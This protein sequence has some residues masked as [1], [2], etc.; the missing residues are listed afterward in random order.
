ML[1]TEFLT[2]PG[3]AG[4]QVLDGPKCAFIAG[5][6]LDRFCSGRLSFPFSAGYQCA[7]FLIMTGTLLSMA[8]HSHEL[9]ARID[10]ADIN[11]EFSIFGLTSVE[12]KV[13]EEGLRTLIK[14][15]G[16]YLMKVV[17]S[18]PI[19]LKVTMKVYGVPEDIYGPFYYEGQGQAMS[20]SEAEG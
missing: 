7:D 12:S 5:F 14:G 15:I 1:L 11:C 16:D 2:D 19:D 8:S 20:R 9:V 18:V 13:S 3:R 10:H 6:L 4:E 17:G